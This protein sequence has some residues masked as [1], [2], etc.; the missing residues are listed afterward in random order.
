MMAVR[1]MVPSMVGAMVIITIDLMN[2]ATRPIMMH[3]VMVLVLR[4]LMMGVIAMFTV[5]RC[6]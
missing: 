4:L 5:Q 1:A 2:R 6:L 3:A